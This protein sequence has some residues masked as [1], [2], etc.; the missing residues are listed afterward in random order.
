LDFVCYRVVRTLPPTR[1]HFLS[2]KAEGKPARP[3]EVRD[4]RLYEGVSVFESL[5]ALAATRLLVPLVGEVVELR[6]PD[7]APVGVYRPG[8]KDRV[9]RR[10]VAACG[11]YRLAGTSTE[12]CRE[13]SESALSG[14]HR[15]VR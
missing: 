3:P 5:E 6:I 14:R 9:T 2:R 1:R 4:P 13:Q 12:K 15:R 7:G 11:R 8:V 10:K